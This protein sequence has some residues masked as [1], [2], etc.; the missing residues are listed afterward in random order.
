MYFL[1]SNL[2]NWTHHVSHANHL[3]VEHHAK[4][5]GNTEKDTEDEVKA[6]VYFYLASENP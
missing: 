4:K 6:N 5:A 2:D 3:P 1:K